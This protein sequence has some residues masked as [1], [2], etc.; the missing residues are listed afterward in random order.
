MGWAWGGE[1]GWVRVGVGVGK[2]GRVGSGRWGREGWGGAGE[3]G[4]H[5]WDGV[6]ICEALRHLRALKQHAS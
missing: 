5:G 2:K 3:V 1:L 4:W 6:G